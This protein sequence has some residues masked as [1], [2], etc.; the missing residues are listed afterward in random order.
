MKT[1]LSPIAVLLAA[2]LCIPAG[3][4]EKLTARQIMQK[5]KDLHKTTSEIEFQKMML[6]DRKGDKELRE[7][8]RYN[9]ETG[10]DLYKYLLVFLSPKDIRGTSL[11]TWQKEGGE[12]DQWIYMPAL[13]RKLKRMAKGS[14]KGYFM[15]TDFTYADLSPEPL[16]DNTYKLIGEE[17]LEGQEVWIIESTPVPA[18]LQASAYSKKVLRVRKDIFFTVQIEFYNPRGK[19]IKTQTMSGIKQ[20]QGTIHRADKALMDHLQR[21]HKTVMMVT[22]R[23]LN[24]KVD[25]EIFSERSVLKEETLGN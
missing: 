25:P 10:K 15:G 23:E 16:D 18:K 5:Q 12:D 14:K 17:K 4:A 22:E 13:G 21:E 19:H 8:R 7:L 20:I 3:A 6:I 24:A 2:A 9:L 1:I 11:L